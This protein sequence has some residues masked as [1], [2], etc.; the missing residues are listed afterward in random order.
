MTRTLLDQVLPRA[1]F[2]ERH[3]IRI[4]G[5]QQR[6]Y[7]VIRTH[8]LA[9]HPIARVLLA[10]RG[11]GTRRERRIDDFSSHGFALIAEDAPR[12][13]VLGLQGPFW[14]PT[15]KLHEVRRDTFD[16]PV[17]AG[18]ARG[19]WNF[20]ISADGE[21]TTETRVLCADDARATFRLYWLFI[22]PFSGLIRI[23]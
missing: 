7:D 14:K 19:A 8:D 11:M 21:V 9:S 22:R 10:L 4:R 5:S 18:V 16:T 12:E 1:D 17:P 3:S 20:T 6:I 15:C 23:L 13:F 2:S